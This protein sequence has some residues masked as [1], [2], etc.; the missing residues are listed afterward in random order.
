MGTRHLHRIFRLQSFVSSNFFCHP[1][2]VQPAGFSFGIDRRSGVSCC[3]EWVGY[4][5]P[6][7]PTIGAYDKLAIRFGY[8][9]ATST[10]AEAAPILKDIGAFQQTKL[11]CPAI[12]YSCF[13]LF[14]ALFQI[15]SYAKIRRSSMTAWQKLEH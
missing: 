12:L 8:T 2:W 5:V 14:P 15:I 9:H 13:K 10:D 6:R 1:A 11:L 4:L 3:F 7:S